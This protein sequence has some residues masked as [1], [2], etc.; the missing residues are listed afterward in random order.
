MLFAKS[1]HHII[2]HSW[3]L[4]EGIVINP[5]TLDQVLRE[6]YESKHVPR[7]YAA[8]A[9]PELELHGKHHRHLEHLLHQVGR[10]AQ[11]VFEV[12]SEALFYFAHPKHVC[13]YH[14]ERLEVAGGLAG[15]Q[16][17]YKF[18]DGLVGADGG[19]RGLLLLVLDRHVPQL[20][21]ARKD[22]GA[23]LVYHVLVQQLGEH[24]PILNINVAYVLVSGIK[25]AKQLGVVFYK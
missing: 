25:V 16:L 18:L 23:V 12:F 10:L 22:E 21:R 20:D 7:G 6:S 14:A 9:P 5:H 8:S 13:D 17:R 11:N 1:F 15:R 19:H 4:K 3:E 24:S 2:C